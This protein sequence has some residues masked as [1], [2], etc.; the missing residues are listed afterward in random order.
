MRRAVGSVV[1]A[2]VCAV[3]GAARPAGA[4]VQPSEVAASDV[5]IEG[6]ASISA[7][8]RDRLETAA[9][10]LRSRGAPT[11]FVVVAAR[12]LDPVQ[13]A[14]DLRRAIGFNGSVLVLSQSPRSL[15]I[16]SGLPEAAISAAF[17]SSRSGLQADPV[18]GTITVAERLASAGT[19]DPAGSGVEPGG[20]VGQAEPDRGGEAVSGL[21]LVGLIVAAFVAFLS[22]SK[23]SARRRAEADLADRQAA[24]EPMVD[25]LAAHVT[26]L[27]PDLR[28][29]GDRAARA[30]PYY[31]EAVLAYGEVRDAMPS[32]GT[33]AA[34]ESAQR[35]LERGLRAAQSARA[36]LDGRPVPPPE[37]TALLDGLC[38]FDPKH[39]RVVRTMP[40][41]TPAGDEAQVPV[42]AQ[43]AAGLEQGSMPEPRRVRR[44]GVDV[45]YW[46]GAG[47]MGFGGGSLFPLFGG[48]LGGMILH[49]LFTPDVAHAGDLGG[50]DGG[51]GGDWGGGGD[52]GGGGD[53]GGGG[54]FGG[55]D[56]GGGGDF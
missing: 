55:G 20:Q 52:F 26:D 19:R 56:F 53:W 4:Q 7:D 51:H 16:A 32:A 41:T 17:N 37:E 14:R 34:V 6:V 40:L 33:A 30:Q 31:D 44:G 8:E 50:F 46:Q 11:K 21:L 54:D 36:V 43:C 38:A 5:V 10:N 18:D 3:L 25:A 45:P 15:G 1:L 49:D 13:T 2:I 47:S 48:F 24:L 9:R 29:A 39:G 42:C 28:L 23:R 35:T 12:P 27:G 22:F